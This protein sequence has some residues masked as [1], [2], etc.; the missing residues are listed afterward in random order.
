MVVWTV[1]RTLLMYPATP[2]PSASPTKAPAWPENDQPGHRRGP[3]I[4]VSHA[5]RTATRGTRSMQQPATG[6]R[7]LRLAAAEAPGGDVNDHA[8]SRP[9]PP[10]LPAADAT[11][12]IR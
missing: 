6:P 11:V 7:P 9:V 2:L 12:G 10:A 1:L 3:L 5:G 4:A 8:P